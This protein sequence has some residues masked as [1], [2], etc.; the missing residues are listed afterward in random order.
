[1]HNVI[2]TALVQEETFEKHEE[3]K[4]KVSKAKVKSKAKLKSKYEDLPEIPDYER[5]VL[6][7]FVKPEFEKTDFTR[8]LNIPSKM[9]KNTRQTT[10]EKQQQEISSVYKH[11]VS[12]S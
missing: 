2:N 10:K 1:M 6:E 9:E 8:D 11:K 3:S 12:I 7:K 5:P 4:I